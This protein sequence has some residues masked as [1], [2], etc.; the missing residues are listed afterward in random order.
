MKEHNLIITNNFKYICGTINEK[1]DP[2]SK[3]IL[4]K[5]PTELGP[6]DVIKMYGLNDYQVFQKIISANSINNKTIIVLE[7]YNILK[8]IITDIIENQLPLTIEINVD[9]E[10]F[11]DF[12]KQYDKK[13]KK[14]ENINFYISS[15]KH[16]YSFYDFM[17]LQHIKNFN[18]IFL[19]NKIQPNSIKKIIEQFILVKETIL[20]IFLNNDIAYIPKILG[21]FFL[22]QQVKDFAIAKNVNFFD[23]QTLI[24]C[25]CPGIIKN[26]IF[27][28]E[29]DILYCP[30]QL[31]KYILNNNNI[32]K[33]IYLLSE[34]DMFKIDYGDTCNDCPL[35][36]YCSMGCFW[37]NKILLNNKILPNLT[38]CKIQQQLFNIINEIYILLK[39]NELFALYIQS[40]KQLTFEGV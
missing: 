16:I 36:K 2:L 5:M 34:K 8:T 24:Y 40:I 12:T 6:K 4:T 27:Y 30:H 21:L 37:D 10:S 35:I 25:H 13:N 1:Y 9:A 23:L 7:N 26:N 19:Y 31:G 22:K 18:Y 32:L 33:D 29:Q 15:E 39:D 38:Y 11:K 14:I 20:N 3:V 17:N 28:Y